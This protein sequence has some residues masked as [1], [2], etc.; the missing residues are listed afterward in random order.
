MGSPIK[1]VWVVSIPVSKFERSLAFYRDSLGLKMQLDTRS[2]NWIE[3]GPDEPLCKVGLYEW[4]E[5]IPRGFPIITG[6]TLDTDDIQALHTRLTDVG[7]K[8]TNPPK[9]QPWGGW[10]ADFLDPDGNSINVVQDP[11]HYSLQK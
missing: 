3:L 8:F 4:K 2:F 5:G 9:Q 10:S 1:R 7:A 11:Q 6:I